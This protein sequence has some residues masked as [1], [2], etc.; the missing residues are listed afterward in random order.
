[1]AM[2]L[3]GDIS[4]IQTFGLDVMLTLCSP[5]LSRSSSESG[6]AN[7]YRSGTVINAD[8]SQVAYSVLR[9]PVTSATKK[10]NFDC[11]YIDSSYSE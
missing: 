3:W 4:K 1:M 5:Y 9:A 7:D 2:A 11:I 10:R 6:C 8:V